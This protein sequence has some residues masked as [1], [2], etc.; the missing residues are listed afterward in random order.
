MNVKS[1][2]FNQF[3]ESLPGGAINFETDPFYAALMEP[4]YK[5]R[6]DSV[7][8]SGFESN[9]LK[10][11]NGHPFI[12]KIEFLIDGDNPEEETELE[13]EE[14]E[15]PQN[16]NVKVK[17]NTTWKDLGKGLGISDTP[18]NVGSIIIYKKTDGINGCLIAGYQFL[19]DKGDPSYL[20]IKNGNLTIPWG[21]STF[22]A[23]AHDNEA[24]PQEE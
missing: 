7:F 24:N 10:D 13:V 2:V 22:L 6:L 14:Q 17:N 15:K 16:I 21:N 1:F 5:P 11:L 18:V 9:V 3:V 20:S 4:S 19:D 12:Q 8:V 23:L